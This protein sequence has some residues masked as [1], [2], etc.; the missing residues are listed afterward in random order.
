MQKLQAQFEG[1]YKLHFYLAPPLLAKRNEKGELIKR[2]YGPWMLGAFKVLAKLRFLRGSALDIF[3]RTE[4]RRT[5]RQLIADYEKTVDELLSE[6]TPDNHGLAVQI[7]R[8]PEE[9]RGYGHVKLRHLKVAQE[10]QA[11]L[12]AAF[13]TPEASRAA[14]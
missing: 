4:E 11:K 5:E 2:E 3:G 9:I 14:A 7:A 8:I 10:K 13:R 12:V 6:L 1:D